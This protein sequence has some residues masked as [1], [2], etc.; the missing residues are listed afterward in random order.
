MS[1]D[2]P[3]FVE[4]PGFNNVGWEVAIPSIGNGARIWVSP[5]GTI[6][7]D[8]VPFSGHTPETAYDVADAFRMAAKRLQ[9]ES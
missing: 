2:K 1:N 4:T 5:Q 6:G 8:G 9:E 7:A 3:H